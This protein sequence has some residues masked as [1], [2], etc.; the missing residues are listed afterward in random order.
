MKRC[1]VLLLVVF[2]FAGACATGLGPTANTTITGGALG[3]GGGALIGAAAGS[4]GTGAAIGAGA[5]VLGGFLYDQYQKNQ[6]LG[7]YE[8]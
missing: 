5:G 7:P 8:R 2:L 6:G 4:P 1:L 3:A